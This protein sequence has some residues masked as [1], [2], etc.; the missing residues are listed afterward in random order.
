MNEQPPD[1]KA[2]LVLTGAGL[3]VG[4]SRMMLCPWCLGG[5]SGEKSFSLTRYEDGLGYICYRASCGRRGSL[6]GVAPPP[7]HGP[8]SFEP[9]PYVGPL[10]ATEPYT[11]V[12][13]ALFRIARPGASEIEIAAMGYRHGVR[14]SPE[15]AGL[16]YFECRSFDGRKLGA[17]TRQNNTIG[18]VVRT[19]RELPGP[20]YSFYRGQDAG[21]T[22]SLW[23]V[24]DCLSAIRLAESGQ[25][26]VALLGTHL[27]PEI[28]RPLSHVLGFP[29]ILVALD[30]GAE[31]AG[32][33][34]TKYLRL[35]AGFNAGQVLL[36][37]DI[38]RMAPA[39][40]EML[41]DHYGSP[42]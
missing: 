31:I 32:R 14:C 13:S 4:M 30:P 33:K 37:E 9:R 27:N 38:H 29:R 5:Q 15:D 21:R 20:F 6:Y 35:I 25:D 3:H 28:S 12:Y 18:K 42:P 40:F 23:V 41:V 17:I 11:D 8:A 7:G 1:L 34:A 16:Q 10:T 26:A 19:W 2:A 24:E 39:Q 22:E 36:P